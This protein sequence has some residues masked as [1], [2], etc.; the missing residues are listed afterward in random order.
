MLIKEEGVEEG[1]FPDGGGIKV[2]KSDT[3]SFERY[4]PTGGGS[5]SIEIGTHSLYSRVIVAGG[6]GSGGDD[7]LKSSE[8]RGRSGDDNISYSNNF[9]G[10]PKGGSL[11]GLP[12][13]HNQDIADFLKKEGVFGSFG[14]GGNGLCGSVE[15]ESTEKESTE[16]G[17]NEKEKEKHLYNIGGGGGGWYGGSG[18]GTGGGG[19]YGGSADSDSFSRHTFTNCGGGGGGGSG[20]VFTPKS[21]NEWKKGDPENASKFRL[22]DRFYLKKAATICGAYTFPKPSGG[23]ENGHSG[24]GFARITPE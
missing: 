14:R 22:D 8:L 2:C 19:W 17:S 20:W 7:I 6:G 24:N 11:H 18:R 15:I 3:P 5:T 13:S 21:F 23:N 9:G 1:G 12:S 4:L 16:K 10:G